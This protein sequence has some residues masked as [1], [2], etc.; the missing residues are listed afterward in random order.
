IVLDVN[1]SLLNKDMPGLEAAMQAVGRH[2][3]RFAVD[4]FAR[5]HCSLV[6]LQRLPIRALKLSEYFVAGLPDDDTAVAIVDAALG[7][8]R[9][10][11]LDVV[12]KGVENAQQLAAL[13]AR[14]C[15]YFQGYHISPP[16]TA[17]RMTEMLSAGYIPL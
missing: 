2:G 15:R 10:L 8:A 14:A 12:A 5:G 4:D 17:G 16:V 3:V 11:G 7:M 13:Q 6:Q 1:E 9:S